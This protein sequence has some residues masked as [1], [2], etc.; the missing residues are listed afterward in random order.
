MPATRRNDRM[1]R[2]TRARRENSLSSRKRASTGGLPHR[3]SGC[4]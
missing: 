3:G 2:H 4:A 1:R